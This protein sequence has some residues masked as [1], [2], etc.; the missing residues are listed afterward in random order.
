MLMYPKYIGTSPRYH[1]GNPI[2]A[3][4]IPFIIDKTDKV[5][6]INDGKF[7]LD[8]RYA[9]GPIN[10]VDKTTNEAIKAKLAINFHPRYYSIRRPYSLDRH[11]EPMYLHYHRC[12]MKT[13]HLHHRHQDHFHLIPLYLNY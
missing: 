8:K 4:H 2:L 5:Y 3:N 1:I 7:N 13:L 10:I 12:Y 11:L 9:K 6:T